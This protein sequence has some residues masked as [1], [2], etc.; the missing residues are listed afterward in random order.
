MTG[1]N[2]AVEAYTAALMRPDE[3]SSGLVAGLLTE[4]VVVQTNFGRA[5]GVEA[6][7]A[8]L[9]EPRTAGLLAAGARWSEPT[10]NGDRVAV[11]ADLPP[12]APFGGLELVFDFAGDKIARVEQQ[13]MPA[14]PLTPRALRL[15]AEIK[16]AV[17]G[18]LDNQTPCSSPTW[19]MACRF[20][21]RSAE[22]SRRTPTIS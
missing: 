5:E 22:R 15:D 16:A 2:S 8:L 7:V 3:G 4:D 17:D 20:I 11:T 14:A 6:A 18:A 12:T 19:T 1:R 9:R 13:T 21:C 10:A